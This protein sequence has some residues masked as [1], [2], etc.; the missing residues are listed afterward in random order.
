M[1]GGTALPRVLTRG[2]VGHDFVDELTPRFGEPIVDKPGL[3][4]VV[5]T[6]ARP[7]CSQPHTHNTA[8][9]I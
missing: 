7:A 6:G 8:L 3:G 2:D 4:A 9:P 1:G 5:A